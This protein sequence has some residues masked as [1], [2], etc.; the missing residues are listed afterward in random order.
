[1]RREQN[2]SELPQG[3]ERPQRLLAKHVKHRAAQPSVPQAYDEGRPSFRGVFED[4]DPNKRLI[5]MINYN[6]DISEYWEFSDTGRQPISDSNEAF[7]IG[8]NEFIYGI[9]H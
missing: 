8:V 7:K 3:T 6:T 1:V 4:N 5:A 2:L 9:T